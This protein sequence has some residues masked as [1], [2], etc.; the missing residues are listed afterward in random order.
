MAKVI[1]G[2]K[3]GGVLN[4]TDDDDLLLGLAGDDVITGGK[5]NDDING[6]LGIDT[7]NYSGSYSDYNVS[8]KDT[9]NQKVTVEDTVVG[10]DGTDQL[11]WVEFLQF[12][13]ASVNVATG[14][15]SQWN[16]SV[17]N[18]DLSAQ[19][20]ASPGNLFVGSGIPATD[21]ILASPETK[22]PA[23]SLGFKSSTARAPQLRPP[24]TTMMACCTFW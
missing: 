12:N 4:G 1:K 2:T 10:R 23:W 8:Y 6:G 9:G 20:P 11:K 21:F 7:A 15:V 13:D 24:T 3:A 17:G 22:M 19:D 18:V 16:Y 14:D 5:G